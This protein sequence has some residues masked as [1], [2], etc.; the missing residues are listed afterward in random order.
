[1]AIDTRYQTLDELPEA[2]IN[3]AC[4]PS[5]YNYLD[6]LN[7]AW[8]NHTSLNGGNS[9]NESDRPTREISYVYALNSIYRDLNQW[10]KQ[11]PEDESIPEMRQSIRDM[12]PYFMN[13]EF[14]QPEDAENPNFEIQDDAIQID[15]KNSE[16][17]EIIDPQ[18]VALDDKHILALNDLLAKLDSLFEKYM[19][20]SYNEYKTAYITLENDEQSQDNEPAE[21]IETE[22]SQDDEPAEEIGAEQ[23]QDNKP[24]KN[25]TVEKRL[26]TSA[27]FIRKMQFYIVRKAQGRQVFDFRTTEEKSR[28]FRNSF[29]R[30]IE[31]VLKTHKN[32]EVSFAKSSQDFAN[33]LDSNGMQMVW[34]QEPPYEFEFVNHLDEMKQDLL[35]DTPDNFYNTKLPVF[36]DLCKN[37]QEFNPQK[38]VSL[39]NKLKEFMA[40]PDKAKL[41]AT[42]EEAKRISLDLQETDFIKSR[43]MRAAWNGI[44][45]TPHK[46][47]LSTFMQDILLIR[48]HLGNPNASAELKKKI[49]DYTSVSYKPEDYDLSQS[50]VWNICKQVPQFAELQNNLLK[51]IC[52]LDIPPQKIPE[53]SYADISYLLNSSIVSRTKSYSDGEGIPIASDKVKYF[54]ELVKNNEKELR[55]S[56]QSYY[57]QKFTMQ[58]INDGIAQKK[59]DVKIQKKVKA[60]AEIAT[61]K[62]IKDMQ[63]GRANK[64]FNGHH[65][66]ALSNISYFEKVTGKPFTEINKHIVLINKDFHDLIHMNEN[67][68]DKN[69]RIR[70]EQNLSHRTKYVPAR[71]LLKENNKITG[72]IGRAYSFAIMAKPGIKA[73]IDF[74]SFIFD[75]EM[76]QENMRLQQQMIDCRKK[77]KNKFLNLTIPHLDLPRLREYLTELLHPAAQVELNNQAELQKARD[78]DKMN[79]ERRNDGIKVIDKTP[80]PKNPPVAVKSPNR[81]LSWHLKNKNKKIK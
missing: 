19:P 59:S 3:L 77:R 1:M 25:D 26:H 62:V 74:R 54:K 7:E 41:V 11:Y 72:Y 12:F 38:T 71:L 52:V 65:N 57:Q 22:L 53:L 27:D 23:P 79:Q 28:T 76:H 60:K 15:T 40:A 63:A 39:S 24:I 69:G 9:Y 75:K 45:K 33:F 34:Y 78:L 6:V 5:M 17:N 80:Q 68:V 10:Q 64:D 20:S 37:L 8:N 49:A 32:P 44:I 46:D 51:R 4:T 61:E 50:E 31:N 13:N 55:K 81:N 58:M 14:P 73:M 18:A 21:D 36:L 56:L 2:G 35:G 70:I 42:I 16:T 30:N 66:F 29:I 67:N 47:K 48:E 43:V